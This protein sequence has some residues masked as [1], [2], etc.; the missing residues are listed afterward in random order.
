MFYVIVKIGFIRGRNCRVVG[1]NVSNLKQNFDKFR[2]GVVH[3]RVVNSND[4]YSP[5]TK[6]FAINFNSIQDNE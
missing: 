5:F 1:T 4:F 6:L 2:R 3:S